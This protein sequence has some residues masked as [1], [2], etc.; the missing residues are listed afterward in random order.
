[1]DIQDYLNLKEEV[2][3]GHMSPEKAGEAIFSDKT[4]SWYKKE[5]RQ[6]RESIITLLT[7]YFYQTI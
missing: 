4:K 5:W 3:K 1:M 7:K 6:K 2:V